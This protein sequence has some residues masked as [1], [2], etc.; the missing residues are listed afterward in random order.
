MNKSGD[1][2]L[3]NKSW[4]YVEYLAN[5]NLCNKKFHFYVTSEL[6]VDVVTACST[7]EKYMNLN[8]K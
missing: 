8:N 6:L 1:D 3:I 7:I 4:T 2:M 5:G